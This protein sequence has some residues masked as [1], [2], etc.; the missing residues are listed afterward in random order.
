M[1]VILIGNPLEGFHTVGPYDDYEDA[2]AAAN[3]YSPASE[4]WITP[5]KTMDEFANG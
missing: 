1:H 2:E 5:V 3:R 4:T